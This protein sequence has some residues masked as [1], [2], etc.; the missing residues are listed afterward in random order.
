[1]HMSCVWML[2]RKNLFR[3]II[4]KKYW[5][6]WGKLYKELWVLKVL[7]KNQCIYHCFTR[8]ESHHPTVCT[9]LDWTFTTLST[10]HLNCFH[11]C[12]C[13]E[14][15]SNW[16]Y[17]DVFTTCPLTNLLCHLY[18]TKK[19]KDISLQQ[20]CKN[21]VKIPIYWCRKLPFNCSLLHISLSFVQMKIAVHY[22]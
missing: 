9:L 7:F 5:G 3:K 8:T 17:L 12:W 19:R 15:N 21:L 18:G 10:G 22:V 2:D 14:T 20:D 1:M 6:E 11:S 13:N 16:H 4:E